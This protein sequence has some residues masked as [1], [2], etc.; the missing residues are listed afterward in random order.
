MLSEKIDWNDE[1]EYLTTVR[2]N[3]NMLQFVK[4]QTDE[5]CLEAVKQYGWALQFVKKQTDEICLEA[6]KQNGNALQFVKNP[7]KKNVFDSSRK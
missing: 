1:K 6:V 5:I 7:T 4:N 3:S 2:R